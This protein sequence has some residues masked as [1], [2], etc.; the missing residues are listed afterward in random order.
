[1]CRDK[2]NIESNVLMHK[3][4]NKGKRM[5]ERGSE[6]RKREWRGKCNNLEGILK[7]RKM[8]RTNGIRNKSRRKHGNR[9]KILRN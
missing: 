1:M 5:E 2:Q 8:E 9:G 3:Y 4:I 7:E 6:G